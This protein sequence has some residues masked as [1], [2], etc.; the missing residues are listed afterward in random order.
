[1]SALCVIVRDRRGD[2]LSYQTAVEAV[3]DWV[4]DWLQGPTAL[5]SIQV[6]SFETRPLYIQQ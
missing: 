4:P 6:W 5:R 3:Y 1:M 2:R